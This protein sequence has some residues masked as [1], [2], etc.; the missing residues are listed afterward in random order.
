VKILQQ[1]T[2]IDNIKFLESCVRARAEQGNINRP[3]Y[4]TWTADL[5]LQHNESRPFL[6]KYLND[7]RRVPWRHKMREMMAIA[8]IIPAACKNQSAI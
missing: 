1:N 6:G 8:G 5:I 4:G 3:A 7:L 2:W